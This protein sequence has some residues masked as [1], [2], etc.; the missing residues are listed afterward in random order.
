MGNLFK[1]EGTYCKVAGLGRNIAGLG[2]N[3]SK[4]KIQWTKWSILQ[5]EIV[6]EGT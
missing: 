4:V 3:S 5:G 2:K 6:I 1:V